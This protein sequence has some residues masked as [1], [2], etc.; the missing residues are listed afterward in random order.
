MSLIPVEGVWLKPFLYLE[1]Y[2]PDG[3]VGQKFIPTPINLTVDYIQI[4]PAGRLYY[5][6]TYGAIAM[7]AYQESIKQTDRWHLVNYIKDNLKPAL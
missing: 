3:L 5:T 7:P 2:S 1:G 6:I 4:Q